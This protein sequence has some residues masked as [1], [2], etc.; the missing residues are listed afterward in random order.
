MSRTAT[1]VLGFS[2]ALAATGSAHAQ[3]EYEMPVTCKYFEFADKGM[4][5]DGMRVAYLK[6][7]RGVGAFAPNP[8]PSDILVITKAGPKFIE[9]IG[10]AIRRENGTLN[11]IGVNRV[12]I[13]R[14]DGGNPQ[15]A[16]YGECLLQPDPKNTWASIACLAHD[17]DGTEFSVSLE[18]TGPAAP[19]EFNSPLY[20]DP[21]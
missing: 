19:I 1:L 10:N 18:I 14:N 15:I 4:P 2:A 6:S 7:W 16:A 21:K 3:K 5:C 17:I 13:S 12:A 20:R 11:W 9:F 8:A